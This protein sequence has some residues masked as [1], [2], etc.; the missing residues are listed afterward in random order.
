MIGGAKPFIER[1][2]NL[3]SEVM[4]GWANS[5]ALLGRLLGSVVSG[6]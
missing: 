4:S 5:C 6:G 2:F 1:Y 3:T